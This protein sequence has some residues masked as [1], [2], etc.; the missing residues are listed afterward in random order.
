L[1]I[2]GDQECD[3]G[4]QGLVASPNAAWKA[5]LLHALMRNSRL[6]NLIPKIDFNLNAE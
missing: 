2:R 5:A 3:D 1:N 6:S 4:Y